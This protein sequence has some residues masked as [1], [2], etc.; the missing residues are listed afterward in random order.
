MVLHVEGHGRHAQAERILNGADPDSLPLFFVHGDHLASAHVLTKLDGTLLSQEEFFAYGRSS[1]RRDGRNRF[2]Y[3]G[4]ERDE[5]VGLSLTGPRMYDPISGRFLQADWIS[6]AS[7]SPYSYGRC[8]PLRFLDPAGYTPAEAAAI[9]GPAADGD[10]GIAQQAAKDHVAAL[11]EQYGQEL[12]DD[13]NSRLKGTY[14]VVV[15]DL[16]TAKRSEIKRALISAGASRQY[17]AAS[18]KEVRRAQKDATERGSTLFGARMAAAGVMIVDRKDLLGT[19]RHEV[20]HLVSKLGGALGSLKEGAT[21]YYAQDYGYKG[22]SKVWGDIAYTAPGA[23][24]RAYF[25]NSTADQDAIIGMVNS[26]PSNLGAVA[27]RLD[28]P[29]AP[30]SNWDAVQLLM[31]EYHSGGGAELELIGMARELLP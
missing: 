7:S 24:A 15:D 19:T 30:A 25:D 16:M 21:D 17:A 4:V 13:L 28:R 22:A 27:K 11:Q 31:D 8:G 18:G 23:A 26:V 12:Q 5:D 9:D 20:T 1:D 29:T 14:I 10:L 6:L 3:I 2:R